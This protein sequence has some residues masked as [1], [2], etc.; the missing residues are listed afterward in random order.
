MTQSADGPELVPLSEDPDCREAA[1][2]ALDTWITPTDRFYVRSHFNVPEVDASAWRLS[3]EGEVDRPLSISYDDLTSRPATDSVIMLECAGNSRRH[4][5]PPAEGISF[6]HGA[7]GNARWT[8]VRL[9]DLLR[10]AGVRAGAVEVLAAG[11]D[12]GEEEEEGATLEI[13]YERSLPLDEAM[14]TGVLLAYMM[15]GEPLTPAHGGPVRLI[16]PGWYGM[17]SVKWL[18]RIEARSGPFGGFFQERRYVFIRGG[19]ARA[20]WEAVSRLAVK[21]II[22]R[23]RHGEVVPP[24]EYVIEG[25]AW[26]GDGEVARVEVSCD[27]GETWADARLGAESAPGAWRTWEYRWDAS[28]AGHFILE[29]A[30]HRHRGPRPAGRHALELPRLRQQRH[31]RDSGGGAGAGL[32]RL[33]AGAAHRSSQPSADTL[34]GRRASSSMPSG[35]RMSGSETRSSLP[36]LCIQT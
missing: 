31:P 23:P 1:L 24:G 17:A 2:P 20:S 29:G 32:G 11:A 15:N 5:T 36:F 18:E 6:S 22:T 7:V 21:S 33:A 14:G 12:V 4:V 9:A 35:K 26:T 8:G 28:S 25:K 27:A 3:V 34:R 19:A 16:V 13:G 10:E 30:G